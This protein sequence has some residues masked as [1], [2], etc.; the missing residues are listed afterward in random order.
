MQLNRGAK[1]DALD[2]L[3]L[4]IAQHG[5]NLNTEN[6]LETIKQF[7]TLKKDNYTDLYKRALDQRKY[8]LAA[9]IGLL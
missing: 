5:N 7:V 1:N 6:M 9:R 8:R 4:A 3:G 2:A